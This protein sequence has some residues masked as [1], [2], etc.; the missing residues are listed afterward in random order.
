MLSSP[1][2]DPQRNIHVGGI[3]DPAA[4]GTHL[5]GF[6]AMLAGTLFLLGKA[7]RPR[8]RTVA[9]IFCLSSLIQYA[10][11]VTYHV[12]DREVATRLLLR[13]I[14]HATIYLLIAGTFV[15]IAGIRLEGRLRVFCLSAIF[16]AAIVGV[17]LKVFFFSYVTEGADTIF[18]LAMGWFGLIPTLAI[19]RRGDWVTGAWIM[20]GAL[21]YTAGALCEYYGWPALLPGIFSFHEVFHLLGMSG[22]AAFFVAV[23]RSL[24]KVNPS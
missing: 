23:W 18:Y 8:E 12:Y 24:E 2:L 14:D 17:V 1:L 15:P 4:A 5:V 19:V 10:A 11:S 9:L 3:A 13:R 6:I 21:A 22:N 20:Y 16:I 7:L